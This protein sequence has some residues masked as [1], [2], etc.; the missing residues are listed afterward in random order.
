MLHHI[1]ADVHEINGLCLNQTIPYSCEFSISV[2]S[3]STF[4][5]IE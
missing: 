2:Y 5:G 3:L 1:L 4:Y